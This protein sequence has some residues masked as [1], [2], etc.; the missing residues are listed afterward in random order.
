MGIS[1]S[2]EWQALSEHHREVGEVH[3]R[4]SPRA[5]LARGLVGWT[6]TAATLALL[7]LAAPVVLYL[8]LLSAGAT[9]GW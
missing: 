1:E 4:W 2:P 9:F 8:L 5:R 6:L 7:L 3:L